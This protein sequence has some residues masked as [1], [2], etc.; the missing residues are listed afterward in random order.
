MSFL[1]HTNTCIFAGQPDAPGL[2]RAKFNEHANE[3]AISSITLAELW[4]GIEKSAR[5]VE[6]L[7]RLQ[8][9]VSRL[10]VLAFDDIAAQHY[11]SIRAALTRTGTP[12]GGND[13]LIAAH[14]RARGLT[15]VTNNRREF[16]RVPGLMVEDWTQDQ[17]GQP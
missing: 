7:V 6:N 10:H 1:L 14:A 8:R 11:G 15:I 3:L 5:R 2:L 4:Y 17:T 16:D 9:F 13:M 12:I